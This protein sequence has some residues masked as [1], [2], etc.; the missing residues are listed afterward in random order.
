MS[1]PEGALYCL[2]NLD[3]SR[4]RE[5]DSS[6]EFIHR[7]VNEEGVLTMPGESFMVEKSF[8]IVLCSNEQV[9]S[10]CMDRIEALI[11]RY[12]IEDNS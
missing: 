7:L 2:I 4:L 1:A 5:I 12:L 6:A 8:R 9:L 3:T 11:R 10:E